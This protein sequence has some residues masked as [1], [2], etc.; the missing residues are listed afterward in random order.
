[1]FDPAEYQLLDFGG[2]R[3]LERFGA[4]VLDRASPAAESALRRRPGMWKEADAIFERCEGGQG[5]WRPAWP[6]DVAW[7]LKHPQFR[8][9]LKPTPA[10]HLGVFPDHA[11]CWQWLA[12]RIRRAKPRTEPLRV[13]NLFAYT[14]AATLIAA[15]AG[16]HVVHLD[17]A[18]NVVGWARR[19]ASLSQLQ[20]API[21]WITE[22]AVR[23]VQREIKRGN[24]YDAIVADPPSYG[25]GPKGQ[26]WRIDDDLPELLEQCG[27]LLSEQP[28]FVLLSCHSP[29]YDGARLAE[30]LSRCV[31]GS[32][33]GR[34]ECGASS[35]QTADGRSLEAG[36]FARWSYASEEPA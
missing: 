11:A 8:L 34:L 12:S 13:L 32:D 5:R 22:D 19:N 9:Q 15:R 10:G 30:L 16:A 25:H 35:L 6:P 31:K 4:Y 1:M 28:L 29:G 23:F 33:A 36:H 17:A 3:K 18:K 27:Q 24:R 14:G 2:G 7:E 20:E 26:V 21:R